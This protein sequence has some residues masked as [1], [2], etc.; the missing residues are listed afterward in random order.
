MTI[1]F[2]LPV[3]EEVAKLGA[4]T[5]AGLAAAHAGGL[6]HR[7]IKPGNIL[8]EEGS[9][10]AKLTDFGL[11]RATQDVKLTRTGFVAGTP[12]WVATEGITCEDDGNPKTEDECF[13]DDPL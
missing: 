1:H 6:I 10:R 3:P 5:A 7:D 12:L 8:I 13:K 2:R 4:Q 9:N 11:A